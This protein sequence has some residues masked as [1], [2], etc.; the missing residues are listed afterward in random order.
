MKLWF[1]LSELVGLPGLPTT[2]RGLLMLAQ[3]QGWESRPRKGRGG[4]NEYA[5]AS[6]PEA[7]QAAICQQRE[8]ANAQAAAQELH[9]RVESSAAPA[10]TAARDDG[11]M[12]VLQE[13][14]EQKACQ[15]RQQNGAAQAAGL[16]GKALDRMDAKLAVISSIDRCVAAGVEL[17]LCVGR[18]NAG[19]LEVADWVR[20]VVPTVSIPS[21][22]RWKSTLKSFGVARLAGAYGRPKGHALAP[23]LQQYAQSLIVSFPHI[24]AVHL[25]TA[26]RGRFPQHVPSRRTVERWLAAWRTQ[27]AEVHTALA[28]PDQWKNQYMSAFGSVADGVTRL[29]QRWEIDSSPAD[30]MLVDG[31]HHLI[32]VI[33]VASRRGRLLVSRTSHAAAIAHVLRQCIHD[34]GVP[35]IV[36]T[37][38][39]TDYTSRHL[40]RVFASLGIEQQC[41]NKFSPWEKPHIERF[42]RSFSHDLLE[43]LPGF[44]G[45]NVAEAA[46]IR[47]RAAFAERL[48]QKNDSIEIKMTSAELQTFCDRWLSSVYEQRP[49]N[50]LSGLSPFQWITQYR[51]EPVRRIESERALDV[52]LSPAPGGDG[53]RNVTKKGLSIDRYTYIAPELGNYIGQRVRVLHDPE[54]MGRVYVFD[55]TGAQFIVCAD[56]PELTGIDR[57]EVAIKAKELQKARVQEQKRVLKAEARKARVHDVVDEILSAREAATQNVLAF[58]VRSES[59]T[60]PALDAAAHAAAYEEAPHSVITPES[61]NAL[62]AENDAKIRAGKTRNEPEFESPFARALWIYEEAFKRDLNGEE[63]WYLSWFRSESPRSARNLDDL[64]SARHGDAFTELKHRLGQ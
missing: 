58:P 47:S 2:R 12:R 25:Y 35:E 38:N 37:D 62:R 48:Y 22:Y 57:R 33:D 54:E 13:I 6:L 4:G 43:L 32:A 51:G 26:L 21:F 20:S 50:G 39:G 31:R 52:L 1:A 46:A 14:V 63:S 7:T 15:V 11:H 16:T 60:T 9:Q 55:A 42:F 40:Q 30:L 34:W 5:L 19:E 59:H 61:W 10:V 56:C 44:V 24:S 36:K 17:A 41:S 18:Y 49:H 53:F 29:N 45:H 64:L 23:E 27:N 8:L 3:R 28:N